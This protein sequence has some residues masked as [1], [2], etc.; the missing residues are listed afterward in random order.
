MCAPATPPGG[1]VA[2]FI[3]SCRAGT[4]FAERPTLYWIPFQPRQVALRRITEMPSLPSTKRFRSSVIVGSSAAKI[5]LLHL[6]PI[7]DTGLGVEVAR[8]GRV[9]LQLV[10]QLGH[11]DPQVVGVL[12]RVRPPHRA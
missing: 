6:E 7:P 9:A 12:D 11:V 10:A 4:F 8:A 3:D 1:I 5:R 2:T